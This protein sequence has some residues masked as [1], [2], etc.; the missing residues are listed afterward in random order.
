MYDCRPRSLQPT[1]DGKARLFFVGYAG[2]AKAGIKGRLR[3]LTCLVRAEQ[4]AF[5]ETGDAGVTPVAAESARLGE[6][7]GSA[8]LVAEQCIGGG[9]PGMRT[10]QTRVHAARPF[11]P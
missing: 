6:F 2:L 8:V 9:Q 4:P 7:D 5:L 10:G 11:Q 1:G 3:Q